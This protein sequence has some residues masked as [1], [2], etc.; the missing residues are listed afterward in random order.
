MEFIIWAI[1]LILCVK[2]VLDIWSLQGDTFKKLIW[3]AVILLT[4]WIGLIF[5]YLFAKDKIANWVK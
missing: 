4:S 2:A 3:I 5:Y 1:G